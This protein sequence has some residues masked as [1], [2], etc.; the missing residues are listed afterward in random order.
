MESIS[1]ALKLHGFDNWS[2]FPDFSPG[3]RV[4][5]ES[6]GETVAPE[7]LEETIERNYVGFI[8]AINL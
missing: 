6:S 3:E 7:S 5:E 4:A 2:I 1:W 8:S